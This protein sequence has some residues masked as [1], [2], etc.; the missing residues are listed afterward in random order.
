MLI[1]QYPNWSTGAIDA[2]PAV[3]GTMDFVSGVRLSSV[4]RE[5]AH[6]S[7][8]RIAHCHS[9]I[10]ASLIEFTRTWPVIDVKDC[11]LKII[12]LAPEVDFDYVQ[13]RTACKISL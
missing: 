5:M 7:W 10:A 13:N 9:P 3:G 11:G 6:R 12:A 1:C 2:A 8:S 4:A